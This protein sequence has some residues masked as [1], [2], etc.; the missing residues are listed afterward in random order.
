MNV[1]IDASGTI[2][3]REIDHA[4][5]L[6]AQLR[7]TGITTLDYAGY[8]RQMGINVPEEVEHKPELLRYTREWS[9]PT[10]TVNPSTGAPTSALSWSLAERADKKRFFREPG[11]IFGVMIVRPKVMRGN[12]QGSVTHY[13]R[14]GRFWNPQLSMAHPEYSIMK[15]DGVST[16]AE[17][18]IGGSSEDYVFDVND[19]FLYG[20]QYLNKAPGPTVAPEVQL[21]QADMSHVYPVEADVDPLFV[22]GETGCFVDADGVVSFDISSH[23]GDNTPGTQDV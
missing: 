9:Y 15:L 17:S 16:G 1:V 14:E 20:D 19:L 10:N 21:P 12:Q 7:A 8:L 13:L 18:L 22:T 2:T 4:A 23:L 3:A 6:W 11:F 5:A